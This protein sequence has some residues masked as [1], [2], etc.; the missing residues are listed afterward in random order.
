MIRRLLLVLGL[1]GPVATASAGAPSLR[2]V[3]K[4]SGLEGISMRSGGAYYGVAVAFADLDG[5]LWPDLYLGGGPN[6]P[7]QLCINTH[8]GKFSCRGTVPQRGAVALAIAAAD[9]DNDGDLD[10]YV[11]TGSKNALLQNDGKGHFVDVTDQTKTG[12]DGNTTATGT[13]FD[14]NG[15]G[16]F[17]LYLGKG[18]SGLATDNGLAPQ[19]LRQEPDGSFTEV[20]YQT[21]LA[22]PKNT[23]SMIAFDYDQDMRQDLFV[24]GNFDSASLFHNEG[25]GTFANVTLKQ[26]GPFQDAL[27]EGMGIDVA[28]FDG[29]GDFD[30]Y[31]SNSIA[32]PRNPGS[33]FF[34]NQGDGTFQSMAGQYGVLAAFEWGNGWMDF[35]N[36]TWPDILVVGNAADSRHLYW[37]RMGQR[38]EHQELPSYPDGA[39]LPC[40]TAVFADY[41]RDGKMDVLLARLDGTPPELL[42]NE[43]PDTGGWLGLYLFGNEQLRDPIGALVEV[44]AGGRVLVR[45]LLSQTSKGVQNE[46][47]LLFGLADATSVD[48]TVHWPM[49]G[50][51]EVLGV[52]VNTQ[53]SIEE[54]CASTAEVWPAQCNRQLTAV[55]PEQ[56]L[57]RLDD[58]C[59]LAPRAAPGSGASLPLL[60]VAAWFL[61]TAV[62]RRVAHRKPLT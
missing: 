25:N 24:T 45:Q 36:D 59:A 51:D 38:F 49:G 52:P 31:A 58:G 28:D 39:S 35:D 8:D 3:T 17:D 19:I 43:T 60:V 50:T 61:A 12:G 29:D 27:T 62:R 9:Y 21:G 44:R 2:N 23:L 5:D 6:Q 47:R 57:P 13:F 1:L 54:G 48:V 14:Y 56:L 15:D 41:D 26:P 10:L 46:R 22:V 34:V 18:D 32:N 7:D 55:P 40:V 33:G 30:I 16:R 37:N 20:T 4:G 11:M 42:H 53:I